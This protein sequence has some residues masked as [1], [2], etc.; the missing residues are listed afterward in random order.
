VVKSC[1]V[2]RTDGQYM[3]GTE[4]RRFCSIPGML[5]CMLLTYWDLPAS[6]NPM[7]WV[8]RSKTIDG[9]VDRGILKYRSMIAKISVA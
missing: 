2:T 6:P 4:T 3:L 9:I 1:T 8:V 5:G 7:H